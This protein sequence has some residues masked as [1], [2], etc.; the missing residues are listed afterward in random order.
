MIWHLSGLDIQIFK[1]TR[2]LFALIRKLRMQISQDSN[3]TNT[4][5]DCP[6]PYTE[7]NALDM[8]NKF[9]FFLQDLRFF[10]Q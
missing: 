4:D 8:T 1:A 10:C 5:T 3:P 7:K 9:D 2:F 6:L